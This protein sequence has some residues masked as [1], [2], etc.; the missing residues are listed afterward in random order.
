MSQA[1]CF[2]L[3]IGSSSD[4]QWTESAV[5]TD[6]F[7]LEV[8]GGGAP[9]V[10]PNRDLDN[11]PES[12]LYDDSVLAQGTLGSLSNQW[13]WGDNDSLTFSTVY[14][15]LTG[16][17]DPNADL[18]YAQVSA[19][20]CDDPNEY[21]AIG[22]MGF[23][24]SA[25]RQ[26]YGDPWH[27]FPIGGAPA[28]AAPVASSV[29]IALWTPANITTLAW[30]DASDATTITESGGAV[31]QWDDKSGNTRHISQG[32]GSAQPTWDTIDKITFDGTTDWLWNDP[33]QASPWSAYLHTLGAYDIYIVGAI[34]STTN[35][36]FVGEGSSSSGIPYM[37][38]A[39]TG[40][41]DGSRMV[42]KI[43][44]DGFG[45]PYTN[46]T[47]LSAAGAFDNTKKQYAFR[48]T[49]TTRIG[50]VNTVDGTT[51]SY[52]DV[53]ATVDEFSIMARSGLSTPTE[54]AAGTLN[55]VIIT[56]TLS[57]GDRTNMYTYLSTKWG[58]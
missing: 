36:T 52:V 8:A 53:A 43:R 54:I 29:T 46:A 10:Y 5:G 28:N 19:Q 4:Y 35:K 58:V 23:P 24:V 33:A 18:L 20:V 14:I 27:L 31:S 30:Y 49:T 45:T 11:E 2:G 6:Q 17:L 50:A 41:G 48:Y 7:Y 55:E 25:Y 39:A 56:P 44:G 22:F 3:A 57:A 38:P 32:T 13:A 34:P 26:D 16:G 47:Y 21:D 9:F 37:V 42:G 12:I 1:I 15:H 51:D 40:S